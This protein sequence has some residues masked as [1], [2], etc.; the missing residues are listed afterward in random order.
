[1]I[2]RAKRNTHA[3]RTMTP[4]RRQKSK[5]VKYDAL[6]DK[7]VTVPARAH[8]A[9]RA[10]ERSASIQLNQTQRVKHNQTRAMRA[11]LKTNTTSDERFTQTERRQNASYSSYVH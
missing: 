1:M 3:Q 6:T 10:A 4:G 5:D 2:E 9:E 8:R 11:K 7:G